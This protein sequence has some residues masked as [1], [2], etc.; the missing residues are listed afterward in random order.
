MGVQLKYEEFA[1]SFD[2]SPTRTEEF[3]VTIIFGN[4]YVMTYH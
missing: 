3:A 1:V 2:V 4:I